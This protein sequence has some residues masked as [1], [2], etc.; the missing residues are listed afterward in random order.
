MPRRRLRRPVIRSIAHHRGLVLIVNNPVE[1]SAAVENDDVTSQPS[2]P[3]RRETAASI[4]DDHPAVTNDGT[5]PRRRS[6]NVLAEMSPASRKA[7]VTGSVLFVSPRTVYLVTF[8]AQVQ[9]WLGKFPLLPIRRTL[10]FLLPRM[11]SLYESG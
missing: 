6:S 10:E 3:V 8:S 5:I 4:S 2:S 11:N 7:W 1:A 9:S